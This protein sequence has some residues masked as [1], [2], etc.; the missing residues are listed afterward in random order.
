MA[1]ASQITQCVPQCRFGDVCSLFAPP[2]FP[3]FLGQP[4]LLC[5]EKEK[6]AAH[7]ERVL[8]R[9]VVIAGL[10]WLQMI[11]PIERPSNED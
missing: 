9:T 5:K 8:V 3:L 4:V 1:S 11:K 2:L 6:E 7:D 10:L